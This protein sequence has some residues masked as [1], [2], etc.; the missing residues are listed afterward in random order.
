MRKVHQYFSEKYLAVW[1]VFVYDILAVF[2]SFI[3][4]TVIRYNFE[5]RQIQFQEIVIHGLVSTVIYAIT[6]YFI[7]TYTSVLRHSGLQDVIK[8]VQAG[9]IACLLL[10]AMAS[11]LLYGANYRGIWLIP[12]STIVIHFLV[13]SLFLSFS[14]L[15]AKTAYATYFRSYAKSKTNIII[16][17]AGETGRITV[18]TLITGGLVNRNLLSIVA[19]ID[20]NKT[21]QGKAVDGIQVLSEEKGL[22]ADFISKNKVSQVI[23]ADQTANRSRRMIFIEKCIQMGL[24]IREVPPYDKW[25]NGQLTTKQIKTVRI[26]DLLG[27]SEIKLDSQNIEKEIKSKVV[28]VTGGAG[29]IGSEIVRQALYFDPS[30]VI[31]LDKA[32]TAVHEIDLELK[33]EFEG[34]TVRFQPVIADVN[35]ATRMQVIFEK[36]KPQII[37]HAAAYK[38]VPLMEFNAYEAIRTNVLGTKLIADLAIKSGVSKFVFVSTDKAINPTNLMGATKRAAEIYTHICGKNFTKTDFVITRFGNVLG[39]SGSVIPLFRKQISEGGPITLTDKRATRYFMTIAEACNL[40]LE[41]CSMGKNDEIFVF[42]MG[43]PIRILDLATNMIKLSGF[44]VDQDI[45]IEEVGLRPGEKL[46]EEVLAGDEKV[47]ETHHPKLL[48]AS[49]RPIKVDPYSRLFINLSQYVGTH[50]EPEMISTLKE[51]VPEYTANDHKQ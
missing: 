21:M 25:I 51:I 6:F 14:R 34:Q 10:V 31:L 28:L 41:A 29:S 17:G 30:L 4:A 15:L 12:K 45:K 47:I 49:T 8:V 24:E 32:E 9:L 18:Q 11:M 22:S 1:I 13:V 42:E 35:D 2:L 36:Y 37:F 5:L 38:H 23:V 33:R 43:Q 44:K 19:F 26:E 46:Y 27:R 50:N 3:I 39:S 7:K 48:K 20:D 40:V 16:F